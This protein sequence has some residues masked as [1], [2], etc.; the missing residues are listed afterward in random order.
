M[1]A[2]EIK[3]EEELLHVHFENEYESILTQIEN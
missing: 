1:K 3:E 2:R